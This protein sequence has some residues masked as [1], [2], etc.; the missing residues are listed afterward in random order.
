M[1]IGKWQITKKDLAWF[2]VCLFIVLCVFIGLFV[3][4]NDCAT[5]VLSG[6]STAISIVLSIV[7]IL[8]TMIEG[9]NSSK[10]NQEAI[11]KLNQLDF[12]L[13]QISKKTIEMSE[14]KGVLNDIIP[15][16]NTVVKNIEVATG[17]EDLSVFDDKTKE[18]IEHLRRYIGEDIDD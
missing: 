12:Q 8:Y 4:A 13:E 17:T 9:A 16:I 14:L 15:E 5:A 7:A 18:S 1:H 6:A 11:S 3:Y 2:I 10:I